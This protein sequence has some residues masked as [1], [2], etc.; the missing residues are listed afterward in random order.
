MMMHTFYYGEATMTAVTDILDSGAISKDK[1]S[2]LIRTIS[3]CFSHITSIFFG[4]ELSNSGEEKVNSNVRFMEPL[5]ANPEVEAQKTLQSIFDDRLSNLN[6]KEE[7]EESKLSH[8][9][10]DHK[11]VHKSKVSSTYDEAKFVVDTNE[12][13]LLDQKKLRKKRKKIIAPIGSCPISNILLEKGLRG[14]A[15][16]DCSHYISE[17]CLKLVRT[18]IKI[19]TM[20]KTSGITVTRFAFGIDT[21]V[22]KNHLKYKPWGVLMNSEK[23]IVNMILNFLALVGSGSRD[24][25][26]DWDVILGGIVA[27]YWVESEGNK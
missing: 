1:E 13:I 26:E 17:F 15:L 7:K 18:V 5:L 10:D 2:H 24:C 25:A 27:E 11:S 14:I 19:C 23:I 8:H 3:S 12:G 20:K 21:N 6:N 22:M 16:Y 9:H 4:G